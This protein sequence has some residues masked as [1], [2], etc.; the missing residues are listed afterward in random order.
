MGVWERAEYAAV[1]LAVLVLAHVLLSSAGRDLGVM[2]PAIGLT[3]PAAV[4]TAPWRRLTPTT[5]ALAGA[6]PLGALVVC[7]VT[8][9][10]FDYSRDLA[11]WG[12]GAAAAVAFF[13]FARTL[14]RR[15][16]LGSA[17][18]VIGFYEF[19]KS[20]VAW[21]GGND[22]SAHM[23]GT[24]YEQDMFGAFMMGCALLGLGLALRGRS[25]ARLVGLVT[26]PVAAAGVVFSA[27]R[28][29]EGLLGV[30][31]LVG[32]AVVI[33]ASRARWRDAGTWLAVGAVAAGLVVLLTS[34]LVFPGRG[35]W[36]TAGISATTSRTGGDSA[37]F[38]F[39][40]RTIY[41]K[42]AVDDFTAHPLVGQGFGSYGLTFGEHG[43][44]QQGARAS[45][46]AHD[47]VLQNLAE[48]GLVAGLPLAAAVLGVGFLAVE[49][50][51]ASTWLREAEGAVIGGGLA[52]LGL[53]VHA[54]VDFDW[55]F[56]ALAG[57]L[58]VA[59]ACSRR[60]TERRWRVSVLPAAWIVG[61]GAV[62]VTAV[63]IYPVAAYTAVTRRVQAAE[64]A[65]SAG[66]YSRAAAHAD[67]RGW[68]LLTDSQPAAFVVSAAANSIANGKALPFDRATIERA[69]A[70]TSGLATVDSSTAID[71]LWVVLGEGRPA[72]ALAGGAAAYQRYGSVDPGLVASYG[73]LLARAGQVSRAEEVLLAGVKRFSFATYWSPD[74][75]LGVGGALRSVA[76]PDAE[77]TACAWHL[78]VQAFPSY[79]KDVQPLASRPPGRPC[80][81]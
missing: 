38:S 43:M 24:F 44:V 6:V 60:Q 77:S 76:G 71:R 50:L 42:V 27:S 58:V 37:G 62:A 26:T 30:L 3:L 13:G 61:V 72:D 20:F 63:S 19:W 17:V 35:H 32:A 55:T 54:L 64:R 41:W 49:A 28:A 56:P 68:P 45:R 46:Y 47:G 57:L 12:Y 10:H 66:S 11:V 16:A 74:D 48:G 29:S 67:T 80:T 51:L 69:M 40:T 73:Q 39:K 18:C 5:L 75:V 2:A 65:A 9:L 22:P 70:R 53:A 1:A 23:L 7:L 79:T 33:P 31:F 52:A 78:L 81:R 21:K 8:P 34:P 25:W 4:L 59:A 36:G 15:E 14:D